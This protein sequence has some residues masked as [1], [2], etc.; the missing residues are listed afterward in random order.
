MPI[1]S[2]E[3]RQQLGERY[4]LSEEQIQGSDMYVYHASNPTELQRHKDYLTDD[5]D[6][7][8][9]STVLHNKVY[10]ALFLGNPVLKDSD[11]IYTEIME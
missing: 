6:I 2:E 9:Y 10:E 3:K 7:L 8:M 5:K 4:N 1:T 11:N